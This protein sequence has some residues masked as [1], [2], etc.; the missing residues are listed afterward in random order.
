[1][2]WAAIGAYSAFIARLEKD[3]RLDRNR[4][5]DRVFVGGEWRVLLR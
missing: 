1:M 3:T 5:I 4:D 2:G